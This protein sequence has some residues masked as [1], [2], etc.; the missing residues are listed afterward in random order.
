MLVFPESIALQIYKTRSMTKTTSDTIQFALE[1]NLAQMTF[2]G[3][4]QFTLNGQT[5]PKSDVEILVDGTITPA[6]HVSPENRL[7]FYLYDE[8]IFKFKNWPT[9]A[10]SFHFTFD[11]NTKEVGQVILNVSDKLNQHER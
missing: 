10:E 4:N 1:N 7:I 11:F 3:F 8:L 9:S 6:D 2:Y 5:I